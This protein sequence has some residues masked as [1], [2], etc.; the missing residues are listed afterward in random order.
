MPPKSGRPRGPAASLR[1]RYLL[2]LSS[3]A[4]LSLLS[5]AVIQFALAG[6]DDAGRVV[7]IAGRQRMLS[8]KIAKA[9]LGILEAE[10]IRERNVWA[11]EL[12]DALGLWESSHDA[13]LFGDAGLGVK[14]RNSPTVLALFGRIE[15]TYN[16][17]RHAARDL[18][19]KARDPLAT[20]DEL[21]A[22]AKPV[23][24]GEGPFL[25][26]MNDIT[27][28]Y[29]KETGD[30]VAFARALEIVLLAVM[31]ATLAL[32]ALFIFR[33]GER[34]ISEYFW[35]LDAALRSNRNLLRELQHRVKNT[36]LTIM[37]ILSFSQDTAKSEETRAVLD[38]VLARTRSLA[39]LYALLYASGSPSEVDASDYFRK[40]MSGL[41]AAADSVVLESVLE[42]FAIPA[43][44]AAPLGIIVS[45]LVT[46]ALKHAFPEGR[47]GRITLR[48][49]KGD[50]EVRLFLEDDGIGYR[51]GGTAPSGTGTGL[52]LVSELAT[53]IGGSFSVEPSVP[54]TRCLV[55]FPLPAEA[56][57]SV[58]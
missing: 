24:D 30:R 58:P 13:L 18:A 41:G 2:A 21:E 29:D 15:S 28:Q 22:L 44:K 6:N 16:L 37:G 8:Q 39:E 48:L 12:S 5:Q 43:S 17:V 51:R 32:E 7:N 57:S 34:K 4:L 55:R 45:E 10:E 33:P 25:A 26:G 40:I 31:L 54:G 52:T 9:T 19:A 56:A 50:E 23:L 1:R 38:S 36:L 47:E 27:F 3:I 53:Q 46:N 49:E 14:G 20:H 11:T 35:E 42:S